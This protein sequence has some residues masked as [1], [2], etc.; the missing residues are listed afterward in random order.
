MLPADDQ[1]IPGWVRETG[2]LQNAYLQAMRCDRATPFDICDFKT[3]IDE[4]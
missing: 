3:R 2:K 4:V 1:E